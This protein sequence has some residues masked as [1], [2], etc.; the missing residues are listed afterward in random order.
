MATKSWR[1]TMR[2]FMRDVV[3]GNAATAAANAIT[4]VKSAITSQLHRGIAPTPQPVVQQSPLLT[5]L[6]ITAVASHQPRLL[7]SIA[8]DRVFNDD[9]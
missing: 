4:N 9:R 5:E 6:A 1:N 2:R 7:R 3:S 8:G